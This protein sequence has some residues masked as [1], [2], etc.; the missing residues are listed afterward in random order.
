MHARARF[1]SVQS[2]LFTRR[3]DITLLLDKIGQDTNQSCL[4]RWFRVKDPPKAVMGLWC[5]FR[6]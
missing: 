6:V 4:R 5:G 3:F 2:N 1:A